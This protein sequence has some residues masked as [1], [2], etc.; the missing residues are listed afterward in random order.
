MST[1]V[2]LAIYVILQAFMWA[3]GPDIP[4]AVYQWQIAFV[5]PV[6]TIS[7]IYPPVFQS[8]NE[9]QVNTVGLFPPAGT[10]AACL[11][12]LRAQ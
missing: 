8:R 5:A 3:G 12:T 10:Y 9:C 4:D 11:P 2:D 7:S 6:N 1:S